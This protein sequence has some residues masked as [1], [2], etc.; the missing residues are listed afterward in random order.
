[1]RSMTRRGMLSLTA[2]TAVG[3]AA[4]CSAGSVKSKPAA[5][6]P[7]AGSRPH[8]RPETVRM[9]GDGSTADTGHAAE[10]AGRRAAGAGADARRSS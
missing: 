9:I 4:G 8:H 2:G 1:M 7:P 10:P 6:A 3:A 5:A